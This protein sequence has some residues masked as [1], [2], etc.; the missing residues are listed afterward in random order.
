M[1][2][3]LLVF[4]LTVVSQNNCESRT[5]PQ[6]QTQSASLSSKR[7]QAGSAAL[8]TCCWLSPGKGTVHPSGWKCQMIM[9]C[10]CDNFFAS[11]QSLSF[12]LSTDFCAVM[13]RFL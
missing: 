5:Q 13:Q 12:L 10:L 2:M 9:S 1:Q 11:S 6:E 3:N 8:P 4:A 7:R